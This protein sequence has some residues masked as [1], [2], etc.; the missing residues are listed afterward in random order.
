MPGTYRDGEG[1]SPEFADRL[2]LPL[3]PFEKHRIVKGIITNPAFVGDV[4]V[5][6]NPSSGIVRAEQETT[7]VVSTV[8][9]LLGRKALRNMATTLQVIEAVATR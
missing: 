4:N 1:L 9:P 6:V 7:V 3:N 8:F 2:K 5:L